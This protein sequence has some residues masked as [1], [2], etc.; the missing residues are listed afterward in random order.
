MKMGYTYPRGG[1]TRT[2]GVHSEVSRG[3][4]EA[5]NYTLKEN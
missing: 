2:P 5:C 4:V 3:Y 1:G